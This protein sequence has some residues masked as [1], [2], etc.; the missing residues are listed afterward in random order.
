M[1]SSYKMCSS[2]WI[3]RV[4]RP[5]A[6]ALTLICVGHVMDETTFSFALYQHQKVPCIMCSILI[7]FLALLACLHHQGLINSFSLTLTLPLST[8]LSL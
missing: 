8:A 5:T 3:V 2:R 6:A 1:E 7:S 4:N